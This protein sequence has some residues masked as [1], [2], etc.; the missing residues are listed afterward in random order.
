[1]VW[2]FIALVFGSVVTSFGLLIWNAVFRRRKAKWILDTLLLGFSGLTLVGI[3]MVFL[4]SSSG[5]LSKGPQK[6]IGEVI[7]VF[8]GLL[9]VGVS[10]RILNLRPGA[11]RRIV[12]AHGQ[13]VVPHD[14]DDPL[15]KEIEDDFDK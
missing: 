5:R 8:A 10:R 1:M 14:A 3:V 9:L 13:F 12:S 15:P 6:L 2:L 7:M 11:R 4:K